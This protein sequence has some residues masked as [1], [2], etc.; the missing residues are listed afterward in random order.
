LNV[1]LDGKKADLN[2]KLPIKEEKLGMMALETICCDQEKF[3]I[4]LGLGVWYQERRNKK[5]PE[6]PF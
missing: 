4:L 2:R 3:Q 5:G 6:G 1:R